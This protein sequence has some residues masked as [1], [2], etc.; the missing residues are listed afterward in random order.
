MNI[1]AIQQDAT[2][3]GRDGFLFGG[4]SI[5]WVCKS[6]SR[7]CKFCHPIVYF[8]NDVKLNYYTKFPIDNTLGHSSTTTTWHYANCSNDHK[9]MDTQQLYTYQLA[10]EAWRCLLQLNESFVNPP[11]SCTSTIKI[12]IVI[13]QP[14]NHYR[15]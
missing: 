6:W 1:W 3:G 11:P 15:L 14:N 9:F 4:H 10:I 12:P 2:M 8:G 5:P 7:D 13:D